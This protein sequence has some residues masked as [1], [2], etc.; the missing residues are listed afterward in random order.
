MQV[1]V[2][3]W[4][5]RKHEKSKHKRKRNVIEIHINS[6]KAF[7]VNYVV[8]KLYGCNYDLSPMDMVVEDEEHF[9]YTISSDSFNVQFTTIDVLSKIKNSFRQEN[10]T[11][12]TSKVCFVEL[13]D[14]RVEDGLQF[15]FMIDDNDLEKEEALYRIR[16]LNDVDKTN[17]EPLFA[18]DGKLIC[19]EDYDTLLHKKASD[20]GFFT[21]ESNMVRD[22]K[23]EFESNALKNDALKNNDKTPGYN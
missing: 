18:I 12:D 9:E 6:T 14:E 8:R 7:V 17:I 10:I 19:G 13:Q 4:I 16:H 1:K 11:F 2:G 5:A 20:V 21:P 22:L 3:I 15:S 23:R